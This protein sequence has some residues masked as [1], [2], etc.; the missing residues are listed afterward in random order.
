MRYLPLTEQD[1]RE[2]LAVIGAKSVDE[3]FRG[4][5]GPTAAS[6][7]RLTRAVLAGR[8]RWVEDGIVD[9]SE[10]TGPWIAARTP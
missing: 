1:R 4:L 2:M 5:R 8:L 7:G 6:D 10:G 9:T 3:L